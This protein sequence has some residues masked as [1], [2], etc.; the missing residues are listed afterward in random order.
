M[1]N[2]SQPENKM[3]LFASL[4]RSRFTKQHPLSDF[5]LFLRVYKPHFWQEFTLENGG[6]AYTRKNNQDP[7][8]KSCYHIDN[9]AHDAGIV[10]C[11]TPSRDH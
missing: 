10:C 1:K 8:R 9:W 6:A 2:E 4:I 5:L 3:K 11:E 7:P